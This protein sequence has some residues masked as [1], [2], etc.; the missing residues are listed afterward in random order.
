MSV[1]RAHKRVIFRE[2]PPYSVQRTHTEPC[3]RAAHKRAHTRAQTLAYRTLKLN[4]RKRK[5]TFHAR[6][7]FL[8]KCQC[9]GRSVLL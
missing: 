8:V 9:M 2:P 7:V 3:V 5:R 6:G 1:R 4:D